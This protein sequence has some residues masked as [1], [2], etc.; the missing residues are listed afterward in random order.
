MV[1]HPFLHSILHTNTLLLSTAAATMSAK[2]GLVIQAFRHN[3]TMDTNEAKAT[4]AALGD[5]IDEIYNRNASQLSYEEYYRKAYNMVLKK[6]GDL[7]YDGI[8]QILSK[9][10]H[11]SAEVIANA[12]NEDFLT[13]LVQQ[14]NAHD[15]AFGIV[16]GV[17][18]YVDRSYCPERAKPLIYD[19]AL[20]LFCEVIVYHTN[21][22][23][24]IHKLLLRLIEDER[25]G[26]VIDRPTVKETLNMLRA[27]GKSSSPPSNPTA[28]SSSSSSSSSLSIVYEDDFEK[29]FL[30]ETETFYQVESLDYLSQNSCNDYMLKVEG[31]I[32]EELARV[33]NYLLASTESKLV[34]VLDKELINAHAK[35]LLEME[36][37]GLTPMLR[38]HK[39]DQ[40][41]R[42][43]SLFNRI[44]ACLDMM[45]DAVGKYIV[46]SGLDILANQDAS[47]DPVAFVKAILDL[48]DKFDEI[49]QKCF[50]SDKKSTKKL[51]DSFESFVNRD[52]R[53]A[54]HLASYIDEM[55][56]NGVEGNSEVEIETKFEKV[57][58]I[59]RY[60]TDKDIFENYYKNLLCKRLLGSKSISDENERNM[61][62]KLKAECGYQF[63]SKLEG[64]FNDMNISNNVMKEFKKSHQCTTSPVEAEVQLLTM[65]FWPLQAGGPCNLHPMLKEC[66]VRFENFYLERNGGRKLVWLSQMGSVDMKVCV[67]NDFVL[68]YVALND[69]VVSCTIGQLPRW[70]ERV[71]GIHVSSVPVDDV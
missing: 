16:K 24:R 59:F 49:N 35:T 13:T 45:R 19:L 64:M 15:I 17:L 10:L 70:K 32:A 7:L 1:L 38:D 33:G 14:W 42:M 34:A 20:S 40:L 56:K 27:M 51:K 61:I 31:R 69:F 55:L 57:I 8:K 37:S 6:H 53:C 67:L 71:D 22:R 66:C 36:S 48:K 41:K 25:K 30:R 29:Y 28:S 50:R 3:S 5:A 47:K 58:V 12:P 52:S 60:I 26:F 44:P 23:D 18:L 2:K 63:T 4:L 62:A 43:Y 65:G 39:L 11:K 54:A 9:H 46:Q 68:F 21:I